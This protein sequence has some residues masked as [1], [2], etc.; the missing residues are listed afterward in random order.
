MCGREGGGGRKR[1]NVELVGKSSEKDGDEEQQD[2]VRWIECGV[3]RKTRD[4]GETKKR[5]RQKGK[6]KKKKTSSAKAR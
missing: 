3:R 4:I 6:E 5:I 2:V 1:A